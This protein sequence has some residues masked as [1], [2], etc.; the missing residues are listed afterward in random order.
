MAGPGA[1]LRSVRA[2]VYTIP[3]EGPEGDGT[4]NWTT[5]TGK[6]VWIRFTGGGVTSNVSIV[7][8]R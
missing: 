3:T 5:N 7:G 4:F 8:A 2:R 6:K 1:A